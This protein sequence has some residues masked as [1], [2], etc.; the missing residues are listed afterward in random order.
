MSWPGLLIRIA[1]VVLVFVA[2]DWNRSFLSAMGI[3]PTYVARLVWNLAFA[4]PIF[5]L[6]MPAAKRVDGKVSER[7]K[8]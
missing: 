5:M 1:A 8:L 4:L 7:W 6:A 2:V 3:E